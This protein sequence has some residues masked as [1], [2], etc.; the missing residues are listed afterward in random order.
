MKVLAVAS[1]EYWTRPQEL[2]ARAHAQ[3]HCTAFGEQADA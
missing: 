2:F 1:G 3:V